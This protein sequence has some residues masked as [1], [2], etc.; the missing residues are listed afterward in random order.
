V[1]CRDEIKEGLIDTIGQAAQPGSP[2]GRLAYDAFFETVELLLKHRVTLLAEAAFQHKLWAPKLEP[3]RNIATIRIIVCDVEPRLARSRHLE[4]SR[5]DP[6]R[7]RFHEDRA[8]QLAW[9]RNEDPDDPYHAPE[10]DVPILRVDTSDGYHPEFEQIVSF[11]AAS[12]AT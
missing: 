5:A 9:E 7:Q 6:M 10:L 3:L 8:L 11:A 4:R 1:I 12:F 2:V